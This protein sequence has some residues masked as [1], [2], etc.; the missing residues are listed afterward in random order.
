VPTAGGI[1]GGSAADY[2][3]VAPHAWAGAAAHGELLGG[4]ATYGKGAAP[5][6]PSEG[7]A[8]LSECAL[9]FVPTL[10]NE[11]PPCRVVFRRTFRSC[12]SED[13]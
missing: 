3:R 8:P 6:Y 11:K 7:A 12:A 10:K 13:R 5:A 1:Y 4:A 2:G 9:R